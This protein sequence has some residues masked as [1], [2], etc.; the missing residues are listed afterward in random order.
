MDTQIKQLDNGIKYVTC[1]YLS[2]GDYDHSCAI[3]RTNVRYLKEHDELK[4]SI[5]TWSMGEWESNQYMSTEHRSVMGFPTWQAIDTDYKLI[6]TYGG[7]GSIQLWVREDVW[8]EMELEQ[9]FENHCVLDEDLLSQVEIEMEDEAWDNWIKSDLIHTLPDELSEE[10]MDKQEVFCMNCAWDGIA[11]Q[12]QDDIVYDHVCPNCQNPY[13]LKFYD[14]EMKS[15]RDFADELDNSELYNIY[16]HCCNKTNTYGS[17]ESGG[18]WYID[19]DRL[20]GEFKTVIEQLREGNAR[21]DCE[22][23]GRWDSDMKATIECGL[24]HNTGF[25]TPDNLIDDEAINS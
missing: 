18:N 8:N 17:C 3:E 9:S 10:E 14:I 2:Y 19:V 22:G 1:S 7:Y 5:Q 16:R 20:A 6:E 15:L 24:C 25:Y 12:L 23:N 4:E 11:E 13:A 21:C